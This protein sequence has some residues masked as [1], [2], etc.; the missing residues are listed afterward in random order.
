MDLKKFSVALCYGIRNA[1]YIIVAFTSD[2]AEEIAIRYAV[3]DFAKE[4][5]G[6]RSIETVECTNK[7]VALPMHRTAGMLIEE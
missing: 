1:K 3:E 4:S 6:M 5:K 7:N 2:E